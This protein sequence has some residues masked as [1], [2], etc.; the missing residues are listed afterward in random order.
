[1]F[2]ACDYLSEFDKFILYFTLGYQKTCLKMKGYDSFALA[3]EMQRLREIDSGKTIQ[4]SSQ[5]N[6]MVR[7]QL[8]V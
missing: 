4:L 3:L 7:Q 5:A 8:K 2:L 1:M 6:Q